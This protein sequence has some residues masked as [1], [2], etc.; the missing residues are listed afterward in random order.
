MSKS[1]LK[2][3]KLS[4]F[5]FVTLFISVLLGL[6][7]ISS[8]LLVAR[9]RGQVPPPPVPC[10]EQRP[11]I[12]P[13]SNWFE[14]EFHSLRPYQASPCNP[15]VSE[16]TISCG[17]D[18]IAAKKYKVGP[19]MAKNCVINPDDGKQTCEFE[20]KNE[21][22]NVNI[23][24]PDAEL[25]ILGNTELVENSQLDK[26]KI[27]DAQKVNEYVSWYLNGVIGRAEGEYLNPNSDPED[28][29]KIVNLSGPLNKLLPQRNPKQ[30]RRKTVESA[31]DSQHNQIVAC[32][33]LGKPVPCYHKAGGLFDLIDAEHRLADWK[34][35]LPP[36]EEE[37]KD[38]ESYW[39]DY[40]RWR[41]KS[42]TPNF[43]VPVINKN[44][45]LCF[46]N[47]LKPNFWSNLY[48]YIPFSSTE[49]RKGEVT[50]DLSQ[51]EQPGGEVT[52][53]EVKFESS[54]NQNLLF[55]PHTE[56]TAKLASLLQSTYAPKT[57]KHFWE[58]PERMGFL[59]PKDAKKLTSAQFREI[60][61]SGNPQLP[62]QNP[63]L[64]Q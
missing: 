18:L 44:L 63:L 34:N 46:D 21:A 40:Q 62:A 60:N 22:V 11:S 19:S 12:W 57:Q 51:T 15:K 10:N 55:F 24:L 48:S 7:A 38:F 8:T 58:I 50:A 47:P 17:N 4:R 5:S 43:I 2:T 36:R 33:I 28:A 1:Y 56:E 49:D 32:T 53:S 42:C 14:H 20:F 59:I 54:Q 16:T 25:P 27:T 29:S 23:S 52:V 41:G 3:E 45:Y 9:V 31:K 13:P 6:L 64:E 35:H 26:D 30:E 37:Y 61:F 39:K